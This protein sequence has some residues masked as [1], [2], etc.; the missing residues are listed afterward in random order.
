V[1]DPLWAVPAEPS[2]AAPP[3]PVAPADLVGLALVVAS[4]ALAALIEALLVPLY[5]GRFVLPIAVVL[6]VVGNVAFPRLAARLVPRAIAILL[7]LMVW[8]V[9]MVAFGV[10]SRPEGDVILP[11]APTGSEL[12]TYGVLLGGAL[13]GTVTVVLSMP[14]PATKKVPP[15]RV[16]R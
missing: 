6:A 11:A 2:D 12:V 8:L 4:A 3:D 13:A 15:A 10:S 9:I 1:S 14:S 16:S 7:P 5:A